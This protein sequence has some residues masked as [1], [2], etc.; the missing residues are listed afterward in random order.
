MQY[1]S[2]VRESRFPKRGLSAG[3]ID[4][5]VTDA[6]MQMHLY[7]ACTFGF[8]TK[9]KNFPVQTIF[10]YFQGVGVLESDSLRR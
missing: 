2:P 3:K 10:F 5:P 8:W 4:Y 6:N 1:S 7:L 9:A